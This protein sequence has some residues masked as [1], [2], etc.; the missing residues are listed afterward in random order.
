[1]TRTTIFDDAKFEID[2]QKRIRVVIT[3]SLNNNNFMTIIIRLY[4]DFQFFRNEN[5][6][7]NYTKI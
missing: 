7:N 5:V 3:F 1:M 6:M 2:N 4:C